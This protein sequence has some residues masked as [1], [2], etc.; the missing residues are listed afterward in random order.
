MSAATGGPVTVMKTAGEGGAWGM[1]ILALY[2]EKA[3]DMSLADFL[4]NEIFAGQEGTTVSAT[5]EEINGFNEF[6]KVFKNTLPI[7]KAAVGSLKV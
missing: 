5:E 6:M 1:A 2:L 3:G 7:E 4:N